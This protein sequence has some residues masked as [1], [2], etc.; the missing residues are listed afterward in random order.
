VQKAALSPQAEALKALRKRQRQRAQVAR[1]VNLVL[2]SLATKF[3]EYAW[4][5]KLVGVAA[6]TAAAA[7]LAQGLPAAATAAQSQPVSAQLAVVEL[8]LSLMVSMLQTSVKAHVASKRLTNR[9]QLVTE[10]NAAAALAEVESPLDAFA[11][12]SFR[13]VF[14]HA[15]STLPASPIGSKLSAAALDHLTQ[16]ALLSSPA[17]SIPASLA[18][19]ALVIPVA[20]QPADLIHYFHSVSALV[21]SV[22]SRSSVST[23]T[24]HAFVDWL[25]LLVQAH[26]RLVSSWWT[27]QP[28]AA[29]SRA[30]LACYRLLASAAAAAAATHAVADAVRIQRSLASLNTVLA[31]VLGFRAA[32]AAV[33]AV[34]AE[35][36]KGQT[37]YM[38]W[39]HSV[40]SLLLVLSC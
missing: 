34:V 7:N 21:G 25:S 27:P 6:P 31:R 17:P 26:P 11:P 35:A 10:G 2:D 40:A 30:L 22:M 14:L 15:L 8:S 20:D 18:A 3:H 24:V 5:E 37:R 29:L 1:E 38:H 39:T 33:P 28:H 9:V 19:S 32:D 16:L 23:T 4:G 36:L 13:P 12:F